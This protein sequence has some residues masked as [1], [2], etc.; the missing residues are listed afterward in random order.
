M[1][2]SF[3]LRH[4][5]ALGLCVQLLSPLCALAQAQAE[6]AAVR[7]SGTEE[8]LRMAARAQVLEDPSGQLTLTEVRAMRSAAPPAAAAVP[9]LP[10]WQP[11][12][13]DAFAWGFTHSVYWVR[14][15]IENS[16]GQ[17]QRMYIDLGNPRQDYVHWHILRNAGSRV[18][19]QRSGDREL[20][21][22]RQAITRNLVLVL[23]LA[24]HERVSVYLR[25][26]NFDGLHVAMPVSLSGREPY[27]RASQSEDLFYS[28]FHG[29]LL[30]LCLYN[31]LL[32]VATRERSFGYYVFYMASF[33]AW[34]FTFRGY[35]F[36]YL[37]PNSPALNNDLLTVFSAGI[38]AGAGA[39]AI[40]YLRLRTS[41][42]RWVLR[43]SQALVWLQLTVAAVALSGHYAVGAAMSIALGLSLALCNQV[44]G[45]WLLSRGQREARFFMLASGL[46]GAGT[47]AY[48]LQTVAVVP[49]NAFSTWGIQIGVTVEALLLALGLADSFNRYKADKLDAERRALEAQRA[50]THE[51]EQQVAERTQALELANRR[52]QELAI[53]D[54][55]TGAFNRRHFNHMC[56]AALERRSRE[57][58]L[59]L[60]M[61]DID[62]F[63]AYNDG[64][65]HQAGD[66]TLRAIAAA[67]QAELRRSG[68]V[69]FRLGGEEFGVLF[70]AQ[71]PEAALQF[72]VQL[73]SA[74]QGLQR[75]HGHAPLGVVTASFGLAWW[76]PA[77]ARHLSPE[78]MYASADT[79]LYTA[80][81][82]GRNRVEMQAVR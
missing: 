70:T 2:M 15:Q 79:A 34:S 74:V 45:G 77:A 10:H 46:L 51:L 40:R 5:M 57:D 22:A 76:G 71:T 54:E 13:P 28:L 36:M 59:A 30:A 67:V 62:H 14:W 68:D 21:S 60:C 41:A 35:A 25:L 29:G 3:F 18:E 11:G 32:F 24:A 63:K 31:L 78:T 49:A 66:A 47:L 17:A 7:V 4:L 56:S 33:V 9:Y 39:F 44:A 72:V 58:P 12:P 82:A 8:G 80:K 6:P 42:P 69:L 27:L 26:A 38:F 23:P 73:R 20:F 52:L 19:A 1:A 16:S 61:F 75:V 65:G 48:M 43:L 55:L 53:T 81:A 64:H 50:L 37:W